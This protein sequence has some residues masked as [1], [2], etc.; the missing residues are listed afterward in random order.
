MLFGRKFF[1]KNFDWI[2]LV[3]ILLLL[4][5]SLA[6]IYSVDLS[7]G[8][9]LTFFKKQIIALV[10][11]LGLFFFAST[12]RYTFFRS[13]A[14]PLFSLAF[15][16]LFFVLIFGQ[17]VRGTTGW[18]LVGGLTFQPVELAK[19]ALIL[20][21]SYVVS[22]FG[23]HYDRPLF[24][25]GTLLISMLFIF[26][27][28]MQPDLGS[29]LLLGSIWFGLMLLI[30]TRKMYIIGFVMFGIILATSSWF[31]FFEDYQKERLITFVSPQKDPLGS[32]YNV[33]QAIIAIGSG[34]IFGRGLGYGSQ[35]Q[36]RFLPE[37][38]TDFIFSVIGE[39]LG[40]AGAMS[41]L[42]L[43]SIIFWRL[44]LILKKT[45]NDFIATTISGIIILLFV[46]FS[47]NIGANLGLLPVTGVPMPLVSYGGSSLMMT[48][49]MFGVAESMAGEE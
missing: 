12:Q 28:M 21:L 20:M 19:I 23:R 45:N 10:I 4:S 9:E 47:V 27:V 30:G 29:A 43:Y 48:L 39:E 36:L 6:A 18:F 42:V 41:L 2:L 5:L 7:W 13:L 15:L 1:H 3:A 32:G 49:L 37:A 46:Q 31:F 34:Q 22:R 38:Q 16:L 14:K 25:F 40:L 24:F 26:L 11:G 17:T 33:S 35:S 8:R 44:F